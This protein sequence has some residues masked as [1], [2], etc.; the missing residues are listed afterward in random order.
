MQRVTCVS[1]EHAGSERRDVGD[2]SVWASELHLITV[3][4]HN[5]VTDLTHNP[6]KP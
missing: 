4:I 5:L 2:S 3:Y 1:V 6:L